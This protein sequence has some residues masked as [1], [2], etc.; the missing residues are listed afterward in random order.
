MSRSAV[1]GGHLTDTPVESIYSSVVSLCSVRMVVSL[2]GLGGQSVWCADVGSA[3]LGPETQ[4]KVC[5]MG[6]PEFEEPHG[7]VL[8][9]KRALREERQLGDSLSMRAT[10]D[11]LTPSQWERRHRVVDLSWGEQAFGQMS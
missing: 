9:I 1:A 4:E 6:G 7:H 11:T 2:A 10:A 3:H 8:V 5:V